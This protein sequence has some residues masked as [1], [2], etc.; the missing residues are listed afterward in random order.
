[1]SGPK[2]RY[3]FLCEASAFTVCKNNELTVLKVV[4]ATFLYGLSAG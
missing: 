1:M 3:L 4:F 2:E